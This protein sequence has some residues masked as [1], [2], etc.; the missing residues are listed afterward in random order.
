MVMNKIILD[1]C[2]GTGAWSRPYEKAGYIVIIITLPFYDVLK[3]KIIKNYIIFQGG[4]AKLLKVRMNDIYGILAAPVCTDFSFA[5]TNAKYPRNM[6]RAMKLI[7]GCL[8]IIW[9]CQYNLPTPLAK[10]TN[11]KFWALENPYGLL[12]RYLGHPV[13]IFNPYDFGDA[14]QKKTCLW[15]FFDIPKKNLNKEYT[16]NYI[17]HITPNGKVGKKIDRLLNKEINFKGNESLTRKERRA[18]TP[19]GFAKAFYESNK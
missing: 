13:M 7:I 19:A 12:R 1:L 4:T 15:G 16:K 9:G 10:K 18:I 14:Y 2:G 11:L 17:H 5:K 6:K 8:N 3:T